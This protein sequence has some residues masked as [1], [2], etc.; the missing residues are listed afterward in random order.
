MYSARG[1]FELEQFFLKYLSKRPETLSVF[2]KFIREQIDVIGYYS[3]PL[4]LPLESNFLTG[5]V[6]AVNRKSLCKMEKI[7]FY[8]SS[9]HVFT[10]IL[11]F[12]Y[13]FLLLFVRFRRN[14]EIQDGE[15]VITTTYDVITTRCGC[16]RKHL[17]TLL[18]VSL[19]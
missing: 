12:P 16:Q 15:Y 10:P 2:R 6:F 3:L 11:V 8:F 4:M 19:S 13:W 14:P 5:H 7:Y 17:W 9:L 18:Q 1:D